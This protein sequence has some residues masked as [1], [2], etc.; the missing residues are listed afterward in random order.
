MLI[1]VG[2]LAE[3]LAT[4]ETRIGLLPCVNADV[5]LAVSQS[6]EGFAA[7]FAG[8]LAGSLHHQDVVFRQRLLALGQDVRG[9][10]G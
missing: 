2:G 8:V 10:A 7:D 3:A 1:E 4:L 6:E 5:L 9:G